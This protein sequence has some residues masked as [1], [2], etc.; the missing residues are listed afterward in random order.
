M[1]TLFKPAT[2]YVFGQ[3]KTGFAVGNLGKLNEK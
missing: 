1:W 2:W 3:R